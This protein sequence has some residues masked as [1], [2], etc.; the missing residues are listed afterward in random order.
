VAAVSGGVARLLL[1]RSGADANA[2]WTV[3]MGQALI[4]VLPAYIGPGVAE[5]ATMV[6][7][8]AAMP[9][10]V[11]GD[12]ADG[13]ALDQSGGA[14]AVALVA[15]ALLAA[16]LAWWWLVDCR[17]TPGGAIAGA[18]LLG[19][20]FT[21]SDRDDPTP[22]AVADGDAD[23]SAAQKAPILPDAPSATADDAAKPPMLPAA[24]RYGLFIEIA[25][26]CGV[27]AAA[28]AVVPAE[29]AAC[30]GRAVV[31][32]GLS[33]AFT[34]YVWRVRPLRACDP[35]GAD[36]LEHVFQLTA[37]AVQTA[38]AAVL[39][40]ATFAAWQGNDGVAAS[41]EDAGEYG[42]L[43]AL[44]V[45]A[46][47][48]AVLAVRTCTRADR[49]KSAPLS[50]SSGVDAALLQMPEVSTNTSP[51]VAVNPLVGTPTNSG[52]VDDPPQAKTKVNP[53]LA[54]R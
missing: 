51:P 1:G 41:L 25:C 38:D 14:A 7:T 45:F 18:L 54:G 47:G 3:G 21:A 52:Q 32:T 13:G 8:A 50:S 44:V 22:A 40:G 6:L 12:A 36:P 10:S 2:K 5:A 34:A 26:S 4:T 11:D 39:L 42:A 9:D 29:S 28:G 48:A 16:L 19:S 24:V 33:V 20:K 37:A 43:A 27:A 31:A 53:L 46:V 23:R 17:R 35:A 15:T 30:V 49:R